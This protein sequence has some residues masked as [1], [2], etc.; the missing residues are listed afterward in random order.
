MHKTCFIVLAATLMF[1]RTAQAAKPS[2]EC[3]KGMHEAEALICKDADLTRLDNSLSSLYKTLL[4]N[5]PISEQHALKAEQSGWV[6][7]RN[8]CW[9]AENQK[10]CIRGE[11]NARI[12]ALKDR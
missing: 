8:E 4:K 11:Y 10:D 5:T 6:K 7:G 2:F 12:N 1:S 3:T 9:K